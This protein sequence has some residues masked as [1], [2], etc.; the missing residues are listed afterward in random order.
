MGVMNCLR[1]AGAA[2]HVV[3][4]ATQGWLRDSATRYPRF[5]RACADTVSCRS[6][7]PPTSTETSSR[8]QSKDDAA[9]WKL[10]VFTYL[11]LAHIAQ[12]GTP[13]RFI[14][15]ARPLALDLESTDEQPFMFPVKAH[16]RLFWIF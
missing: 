10:P 6:A 4:K 1:V 13:D 7:R 5:W 8:A 9:D 11:L 12:C 16:R 3:S 15:L 14:S 2:S